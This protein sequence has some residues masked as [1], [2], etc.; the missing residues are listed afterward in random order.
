[1]NRDIIEAVRL[2]IKSMKKEPS[3]FLFID[4]V[5]DWTFDE[6]EILGIPVYHGAALI[7]SRWGTS[8]IDCPFVPIGRTDGEITYRDRRL[9]ADAYAEANGHG[10]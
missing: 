4:G 6:D 9:F 1:M 8:A 2:A 5:G 10:V 7:C 3:A